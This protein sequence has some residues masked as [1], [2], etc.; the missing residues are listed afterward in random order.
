MTRVGFLD[1][2]RFSPNP[3]FLKTQLNSEAVPKLCTAYFVLHSSLGYLAQH[4]RLQPVVGDFQASA[5]L[6]KVKGVGPTT[7][8]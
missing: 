4:S 7:S 5:A 6:M 2:I 8:S 3:S 1:N